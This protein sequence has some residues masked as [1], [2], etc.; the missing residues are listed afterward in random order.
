[1]KDSPANPQ[2][3]ARIIQES[4]DQTVQ[5]LQKLQEGV[6]SDIREACGKI[7]PGQDF[8]PGNFEK[9]EKEL[10]RQQAQMVERLEEITNGLVNNEI[11][12]SVSK[13]VETAAKTFEEILKK[14]EGQ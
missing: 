4:L 12:A 5:S 9:V 7:S 6:V 10:A 8:K 14:F 11:F 13:T 2:D 3:L 1:M